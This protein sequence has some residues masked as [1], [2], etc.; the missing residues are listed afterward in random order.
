MKNSE[1]LL[2]PLWNICGVCN[3]NPCKN[4]T[5]KR[6]TSC[7]N[8]ARINDSPAFYK[9]CRQVYYDQNRER[10]IKRT[11]EYQKTNREKKN[12]YNRKYYGRRRLAQ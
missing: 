9:V 2:D 5:G 3:K 11:C 1:R 10:I 8:R 12:E 4:K 7:M 6:C